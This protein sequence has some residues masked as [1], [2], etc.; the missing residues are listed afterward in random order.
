ME[1][2]LW[3]CLAK[4]AGV[5]FVI[6]VTWSYFSERKVGGAKIW[7]SV[8]KFP[9]LLPISEIHFLCSSFGVDFASFAPSQERISSP[10]L[11]WHLKLYL[12]IMW[13]LSLNSECDPQST[14]LNLGQVQGHF[15][16][17]FLGV[18]SASFA[19]LHERNP[20]PLPSSWS[21]LN[22]LSIFEGD[23]HV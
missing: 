11:L 3:S 20:L 4:H 13:C 9:L 1:E 21:D 22:L 5:S 12:I 2:P 7:L 16:C 23:E 18:K 6:Q 19:P 15:H 14:T 10:S 17:S 8:Q